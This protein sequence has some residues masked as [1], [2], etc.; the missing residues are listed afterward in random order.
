MQKRDVWYLF[1]YVK[2]KV[3][4]PE[5]QGPMYLSFQS[6]SSSCDDLIIHLLQLYCP[7]SPEVCILLGWQDGL[8]V[9]GRWNVPMLQRR[10]VLDIDVV[11]TVSVKVLTVHHYLCD[12]GLCLCSLSCSSSA[13]CYFFFFFTFPLFLFLLPLLLFSLCIHS[14]IV[15]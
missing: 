5:R 1:Q 15:I 9:R 7:D 6:C 12:V 14:I 3:T 8:L 13:S 4:S 10:L 2:G 11:L